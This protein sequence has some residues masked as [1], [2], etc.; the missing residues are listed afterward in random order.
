M[1]KY[2]VFILVGVAFSAVAE[3]QAKSPFEERSIL[4]GL[5][6]GGRDQWPENTVMAYQESVKRWPDALLELD[7]H[8]TADGQVVVIHDDT[9][10][11][12][13]NG[14]GSVWAMTFEEIRALD[15]AYHF[16]PDGGATFPW[17]GK[18]ITI[19]TLKEVLEVS[20]THRFLIEMKDGDNIA[21]AT[22]AAIREAGAA[23]RCV[24]AAV[25]PQF[26]E[27]ARALAPEIATCYD[28][29]SAATLLNE[30]RF[31]DWERYVPEHKMLALSPKLQERFSLTAEEIKALQEKGILITFWT[32]NKEEE[33]RRLLDMGVDS[34]LTDRPDALAAILAEQAKE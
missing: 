16:S 24:L 1:K 26:I 17:R 15:A 3:S 21:S 30:L 34:I 4:L 29:L 33:M 23:E 20:P 7:V 6:R 10:D 11:R 27:E 31:G 8:A 18:G 9:V 25:P 28:F 22:V 12:T 2:L 32:V 13:T 14:S 5:H 19:P